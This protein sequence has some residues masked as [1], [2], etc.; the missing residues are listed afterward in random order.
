MGG[1][2]GST[3]EVYRGGDVAAVACDTPEEY[4]LLWNGITGEAGDISGDKTIV[5]DGWHGV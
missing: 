3:K 2:Q 5:A 1:T 4:H